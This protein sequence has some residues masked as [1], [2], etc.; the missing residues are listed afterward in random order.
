MID[1]LDFC[2][3]CSCDCSHDLYSYVVLAATLCVC[4]LLVLVY[5]LVSQILQYIHEWCLLRF[6]RK[7]KR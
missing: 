5:L 3:K 7:G 4:V 2:V 6:C 1:V